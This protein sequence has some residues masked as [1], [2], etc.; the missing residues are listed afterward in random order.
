MNEDFAF[1]SHLHDVHH[2]AVVHKA[3]LALG[4]S[5]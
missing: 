3:A 5:K 1:A 2:L 4:A